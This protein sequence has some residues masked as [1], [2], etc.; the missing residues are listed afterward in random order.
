MAIISYVIAQAGLPDL[1]AQ[2][3]F[4]DK[5]SSDRMKAVALRY[6]DTF[7]LFESVL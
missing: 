5:F 1:H 6:A 7:A 4:L 2:V 3:R